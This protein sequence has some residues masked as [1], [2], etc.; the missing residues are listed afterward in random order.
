MKYNHVVEGRF[1]SRP[2]RFIA[3]VEIDGKEEVVHVKNTGRC[4]E[5]L[6][7]DARI[8]LEK[9][10]KTDRKTAYDLIAV[11]K[12]LSNN[13]ILIN[14]DS[15]APNKVAEEWILSAKDVFP[16]VTYLKSE[17]TRKDTFS[18]YEEKSRFDFYIEYEDFLGV[19]K[20][21]FLE[22][23]G[24]TLEEE[25]IAL[26]PDAPTERGLRHV[27][28]LTEI[29]KESIFQNSNNECG[30]LFVIQMKGP[31]VFSPNT[32]MHPAFTQA[33]SLAKKEGVKLFAIDCNV[34]PDS[35]EWDDYVRIKLEPLWF[36]CYG[37]VNY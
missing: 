35:L 27:A 3:H 24:V 29:K 32:N 37:L 33:L 10:D 21:M 34:T 20:T 13:S 25:G 7:P 31:T 9:S 14:M 4:K 36:N 23:K 28:H 6:L 2:N 8:W 26:F 17:Y 12:Q 22:V 30:I 18:S 16:K 1:I 19:S 11:E 15:Q 5:L